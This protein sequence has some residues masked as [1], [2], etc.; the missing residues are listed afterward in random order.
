MV[1]P[2]SH[3]IVPSEKVAHKIYQVPYKPGFFE[4]DFARREIEGNKLQLLLKVSEVLIGICESFL[5]NTE[6]LEELK[7]FDLIV[8][9]SLAVCPATM[10]GERH[11]IPRVEIMPLPPN[12]PLAF[13]HMIPMP[14]SYV[15]QLLTGFSDKMTFVERVV[16]LGV[17]FGANLLISAY[18]RPMN[19]LK[20]K[21]N[22]KPD[23][24]FQEAVADAE[25]VM[26][27]ADFALQYA[28]PLLPGKAQKDGK[29]DRG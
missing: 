25:L 23:R 10:I 3:K 22:I 24:S 4:N 15:P 21:Y 2:S 18:N 8:Y 20:V 19:A 13:N 17:Y 5:N 27:T 12:A 11:G 26:I 28:Q 9:D 7:G 6:F 14:V 16:N 1:V 29:Q